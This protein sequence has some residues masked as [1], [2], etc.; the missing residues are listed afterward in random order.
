VPEHVPD[1][2]ESDFKKIVGGLLFEEFG[3]ET[4]IKL[5]ILDPVL[6]INLI[7][8]TII[9]DAFALSMKCSSASSQ[10]FHASSTPHNV[11]NLLVICLNQVVKEVFYKTGL[12]PLWV[13]ES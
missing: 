1:D 4:I 10:T 6:D 5:E 12:Y 11:M 13:N 3:G 2:I 9:N 8:P 7:A